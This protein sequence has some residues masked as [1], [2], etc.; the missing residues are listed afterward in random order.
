MDDEW[1]LFSWAK[2]WDH[3]HAHEDWGHLQVQWRTLP[4]H[5]L[6]LFFAL[7]KFW[8]AHGSC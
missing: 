6:H 1:G 4:C 7:V 8:A 5:A 2:V 3:V